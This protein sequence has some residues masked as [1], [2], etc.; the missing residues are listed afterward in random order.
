MLML[1]G[2]KGVSHDLYIFEVFM[3]VVTMPSLTVVWYV[4]QIL[5]GGLL[6][7]PASVS[8]L[9]KFHADPE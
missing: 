7:P 3:W 1:A 4:Q 6:G 2:L 8:S 9:E 5:G